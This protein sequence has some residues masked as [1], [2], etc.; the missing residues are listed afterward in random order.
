MMLLQDVASSRFNTILESCKHVNMHRTH[1]HL[2][3]TG[4]LIA[5]TGAKHED[6]GHGAERGQVLN[7][8]VSGAVLSQADGVVG[9]HIDDA[10]LTQR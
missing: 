6:V 8:L 4:G 2:V 1:S 5:V 3:G 7:G 10:R 9:H